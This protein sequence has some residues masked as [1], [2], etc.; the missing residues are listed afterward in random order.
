M[1]IFGGWFAGTEGRNPIFLPHYRK[2]ALL[3]RQEILY[4][5]ERA[6]FR[7]TVRGLELMEIA[8]GIEMERD[9]IDRMDFK[10]MIPEK[11][12]IMSSHIFVDAYPL[13][14]SSFHFPRKFR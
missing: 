3:Q 6:V 4:I 14:L 11:L 9:V 8:P 5:I 2:Q 7:F 1:V 12:V 13:N 10:P